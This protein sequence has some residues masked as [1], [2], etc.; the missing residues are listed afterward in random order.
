M[1]VI[2]ILNSCFRTS[3]VGKGGF[4]ASCLPYSLVGN[5]RA[6]RS[7]NGKGSSE[8]TEIPGLHTFLMLLIKRTEV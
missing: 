5:P 2:S 4:G 7:F 6:V 8:M 1:V 3:C